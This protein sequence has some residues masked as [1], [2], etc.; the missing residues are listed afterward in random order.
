MLFLFLSL[1]YFSLF[2]FINYNKRKH[3]V[4]LAKGRYIKEIIKEATRKPSENAI[5]R[6]K[7]A[8]DLVKKLRG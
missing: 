8:S 5:K 2:K 6:N 3:D 1:T 7:M 4:I